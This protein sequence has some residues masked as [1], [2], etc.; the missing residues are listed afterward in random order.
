MT[1]STK[2]NLYPPKLLIT[3]FSN[4]LLICNFS[5]PINKFPTS[6]YFC[7]F[8]LISLSTL[9]S[10]ADVYCVTNNF[11][12]LKWQKCSSPTKIVIS[13]LKWLWWRLLL[14][15]P[16]GMD[17]SA[18]LTP[19]LPLDT[20]IGPASD[21]P[22]DNVSESTQRSWVRRVPCA[23]LSSSASCAWLSSSDLEV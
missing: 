23:W 20:G 12:P 15:N 8:P 22:L 19:A 9:R 18:H 10:C 2:I 7:N 6:P 5:L 3:F 21:Y 14:H 13:P 1:F 16:H 17:A 11:L 4:C